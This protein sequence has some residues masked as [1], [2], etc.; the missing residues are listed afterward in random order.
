MIE[1]VTWLSRE[2]SFDLPI[3]VFPSQL[4]RLRGTPVRAKELIT[5]LPEEMLGARVA[6]KWSVKEHF[7]HLADLQ[8]LDEKRLDEFLARIE[9]LSPADM[10]NR[11]TEDANYRDVP[12][13]D[14]LARLAT[15]RDHL[16]ERLERLT[17]EEV[18]IA[19]IHPRLRR[20]MRIVDW[21]YFV[22]E[23]DDH[24]LALARGVI[25]KIVDRSGPREKAG[26]KHAIVPSAIRRVHGDA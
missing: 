16:V 26:R 15:G 20:P 11:A 13:S 24:H 14:I 21:V 7:G 17:E 2:F 23:H 12:M 1:Q 25:V 22:S 4:E 18:G 10:Q 8:R 5:D 6:A 19:A 3:R 9:V